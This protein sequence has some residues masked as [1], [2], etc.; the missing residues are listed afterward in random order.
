MK[1]ILK[2]VNGYSRHYKIILLDEISRPYEKVVNDRIIFYGDFSCSSYWPSK[3]EKDISEYS[4]IVLEDPTEGE[5]KT[6]MSAVQKIIPVPEKD[7]LNE[8][9]MTMIEEVD[10]KFLWFKY[11]TKKYSTFLLKGNDLKKFIETHEIINTPEEIASEDFEEKY[12]EQ[13]LLKYIENLETA[14]IR[15]I[16]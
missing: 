1:K 11:K 9:A 4:S 16:W 5:F 14:K 12:D 7:E 6:P 8:I 10:E 3:T 15:A 2:T 13:A